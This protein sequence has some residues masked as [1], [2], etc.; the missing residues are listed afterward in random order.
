MNFSTILQQKLLLFDGAMGT[1]LQQ[2]GLLP[3]GECPERLNI[4]HP[5]DVL[6]I[7]TAY[8]LA[9]ADIITA[10]TFGANPLRLED[11]GLACQMEEIIQ[12]AVALGKEAVSSLNKPAY[13]AVS[14]GPTGRLLHDAPSMATAVYQAY[15][16]QCSVA[17]AAGADLF[18]IETM[19]D[20]AEARLALLAAR[21]AS[22]IPIVA[23]F[24]LE[25]DDCTFA[26]NP[27]E[28]LALCCKKLGASM[29]GINC[30]LGP[31]EAFSG[32]SRF[33]G[34]G[35]LPIL[36]LPNAGLPLDN[37]KYPFNPDAFAAEMLP[38]VQGGAQA[39]GGCC[40]T[41]PEHIRALRPLLDQNQ[42]STRLST[43]KDEYIC[44]AHN[45]F[46]LENLAD[47]LPTVQVGSISCAQAVLRLEQAAQQAGCLRLDL[48]SLDAA[49]VSSLLWECSPILSQIPV[50]F[51]VH[52]AQQANAALF[53]YCGI[54]AVEADSDT[55]QVMKVAS[56]F[57]AEILL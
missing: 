33:V 3:S 57:G 25:A 28:V 13:V 32:F 43:I 35:V 5:A 24:T 8:L 10:N 30:G 44:S 36:A 22:N 48:G 21:A 39:I 18:V 37:G 34:A 38:Y 46:P 11:F 49:Q 15:Y 52:S 16:K 1:M 6:D 40:G 2:K 31:A 41:T 55:N 45:R 51:Q 56:R 50:V 7:H 47:P 42:G 17:A 27:P 20:L 23:C 54:A 12:N 53:S 9:G 29:A 26:G 4:T 19:S 14:I